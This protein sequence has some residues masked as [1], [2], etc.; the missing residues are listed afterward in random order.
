[1]FFSTKI[2]NVGMKS[3]FFIL[4]HPLHWK[5]FKNAWGANPSNYSCK[6]K[7][8]LISKIW[9]TLKILMIAHPKFLTSRCQKQRFLRNFEWGPSHRDVRSISNFWDFCSFAKKIIIVFLATNAP[10]PSDF[11]KKCCRLFFDGARQHYLIQRELT[12]FRLISRHSWK[13]ATSVMTKTAQ[14][15]TSAILWTEILRKSDCFLP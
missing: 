13:T 1:M 2:R 3:V 10:P 14:F 6:M 8:F 12:P 11:R 4:G 15:S 9:N 5:S 7:P